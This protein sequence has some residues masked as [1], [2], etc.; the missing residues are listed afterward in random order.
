MSSTYIDK[1]TI[2]SSVVFIKIVE[3]TIYGVKSKVVR[4]P[5]NYTN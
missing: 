5:L 4:K 2:P 1:M 3:S